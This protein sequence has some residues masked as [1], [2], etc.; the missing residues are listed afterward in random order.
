MKYKNLP[1][2]QRHL[3]DLKKNAD[4][5]LTFVTDDRAILLANFPVFPEA[6]GKDMSYRDWYQGVSS[7][8]KPYISTVFKLVIGDKTL[9]AAV[10]VPIFDEKERPIGI[11]ATSHRLNYLG[12]TI[13]R[14]PFNPYTTVNVI[15]RAGQILYSNRY[16]YRETIAEYPHLQML[17]RALKDK[18]QQIEDTRHEDSGK[19]YLTVIPIGGIGWTVTIERSLK[20]IYRSEFRR[21]I[22]IA[23]VA[24][25]LFLL[26]LFFLIYL[27][28]V[29]LFRKT[30][31]LLQAEKKLRQ[32]EETLRA[33]S[34]R[35]GAILATVPAIIMEVDNNRV[36]TWANSVGTEFF[37]EDVIGKEAA[38]Y[39]EG[40]QDTYDTV[41]PLF[42][43]GADIIY[44]ES[45]QRRRD[46]QKRLLAW[47]C[48]VL[49]DEKGNVSGALSSAY[50]FTE[51]KQ[52]EE[53]IRK[54]NEE[55]EQRVRDR[56]A[57]WETANREL[58]AFSY[59]VSHDL[60]GPL[61]AIDGFSRLLLEDYEGKLDAEGKRLFNVIRTNAQRMDQLITDL[62]ALSRVS[63]NELKFSRVD[64]AAM[65]HSVYEELASLE[66]RQKFIF[67]VAPLPECT[68]DPALLRQ[69][70]SNLL[71]NAIKY[72]MPRD[73]RRIEIAG[74]REEGMNIY[75][76]RDTGVGFNPVYAHKLFGVFQRLHKSTEF[77]GNGVG[78]AI[79]QRIVHRHGGRAWAEGKVNEGAMFSFSLPCKE[80]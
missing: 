21:F 55:L 77:E 66:V 25:L 59:S 33:L 35:H 12:E 9:A 62:L 36:Y 41:R 10:C 78:L 71:S 74:H 61:R 73:E 40:E 16:A 24:S 26:L 58:E 29:T 8:W 80:A 18:R 5:D 14:V 7:H 3:T 52:A 17:D 75:S 67:T 28:K 2:V 70:W 20:D 57:Q 45:W 38:F 49:R 47:W 72:T 63:K 51:R 22:E 65:A 76:V 48:R 54:L 15:D 53:E 60:R 19:L 1:G 42:N 6:I 64:M 46:G 56:T 32:E 37:G 4:I 50:D 11:L 39:F 31:E 43:G 69:V 23:A 30:E 27:R 34:T 44:V 79:V 68:G 13:E